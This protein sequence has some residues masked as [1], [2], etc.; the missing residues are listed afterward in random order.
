MSHRLDIVATIGPASESP[1]MLEAMYDAGMTIAR[2]NFSHGNLDTH[3]KIVDAIKEVKG[4]GKE[5]KMLQDLSG[6][7]IRIGDFYQPVVVL[8][9]GDMFV[10]TTQECI[11]NE[12]RAYI[13]YPKLPEEVTVGT[14]ILL[15][16][17]KKKLKVTHIEGNEVH[18]IIEVGGETKGR[19]GVNIPE[20]NLTIRSLT[21]KDKKDVLFGIENGVEYIAFSFVRK[22]EDVDELRA[23]LKENNSTAK[24]VAKIETLEVL[25]HLDEIIEKSDGI[26][27]ARGDLAVEV[28]FAKVPLIQKD[29]IWRCN[30]AGKFVIT[31]TQMLES[32]INSP[33]PTRAEVSDVANS[34]LDGTDAVML[35]EESALGKYP[36]KAVAVFTEIYN[37][38]KHK[39][40]ERE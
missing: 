32:M 6:P 27:V 7:K 39:L 16:D 12:H 18:T 11:G 14:A 37:E 22:P 28:G 8:K 9:E 34:I 24:I 38:V 29:L 10:L 23:I 21:E 40:A 35:S 20:A 26:M 5:I 1:E 2:L 31:A 17:G 25:Q 30:T 36:V 33:I 19:R 15:D 4:T 13:N 3:Q